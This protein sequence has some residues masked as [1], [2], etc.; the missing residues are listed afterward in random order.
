MPAWKGIVGKGFRPAEF[1]AYVSS[2]TFSEWR[3]QFVVVHNT[4]EPR[5]SEW[6][7]TPGEQRMRNLEHF[8]RDEQNWSAGPH[9]FI[10][11]DLI[12]VFT[13]LTVSGV[14][15]PSWNGVAWGVEMVGEYE[16]EQFSPAVRENA[17]DA[18]AGLHSCRGLNPDTLRFHK[19]DPK[20]THRTCPGRNVDKGDLIARIHNRMNGGETGEHLAPLTARAG[21]G[22]P[23]RLQNDPAM[24]DTY[25]RT[26]WGEARGEERSGMEAVACVIRNRVR[27]PRW[28]GKDFSSVCLAPSQFSC[29]NTDDPNLPKLKAVTDADPQFKTALAVADAAASGTLVDP[30]ENADSYFAVGSK[31]P[32]WTA[33]ATRTCIIGHHA[34]YRVELPPGDGFMDAPTA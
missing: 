20:T 32:F 26:I 6:H 10:A 28:W 30:T 8:Y 18:L 5:L 9:L 21:S 16:I 17:V 33:K 2:L 4:S 27:H 25:A 31:E 13:P 15:S 7:S 22:A 1:S 19:E 11:D 23:S 24:I 12:W 14:H 29:W 3:P 34:F